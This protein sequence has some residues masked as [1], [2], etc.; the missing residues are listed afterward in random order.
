L[1]DLS[2]PN[3]TI[4][5][6]FARFSPLVDILILRHSRAEDAGPGMSDAD[7]KLTKKGYE[8][9]EAVAHW[10]ASQRMPIDLIASSPLVRAMETAEI[11]AKA[12]NARD[13]VV[14]WKMLAPGGNPDIVCRQIS[15]HPDYTSILLVGHEPLLSSLISRIIAGDDHAAII[16]TKGALAKIQDFSYIGRPSGSLN[17]LLTA[18]QMAGMK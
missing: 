11:V 12:F 9:M 15:R 13:R 5:L 10:I 3:I 17:W 16:M 4:F 8:E 1:N 18:K 14:T 2:I 6:S 7:R